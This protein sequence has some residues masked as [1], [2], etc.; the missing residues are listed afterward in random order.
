MAF[1]SA[2]ESWFKSKL[3]EAIDITAKVPPPA[4]IG[5]TGSTFAGWP[6]EAL[7]KAMNLGP[8]D[9]AKFKHM[10]GIHFAPAHRANQGAMGAI[11]GGAAG[12]MQAGN[13]TMRARHDMEKLAIRM[14]WPYPV[15][16]QPTG[17]TS[18]KFAAIHIHKGNSKMLVFVAMHNDSHVTIEDDL[19]LYPSDAL[20]TTLRILE[21]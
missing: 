9:E 6:L 16:G 11:G 8:N 15:G 10:L 19:G 18:P 13:P 5:S 12:A 21:G 17:W 1:P 3:N 7:T 20:V 2:E 14:N 4:L